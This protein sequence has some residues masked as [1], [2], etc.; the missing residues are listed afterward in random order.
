MYS[1]KKKATQLYLVTRPLYL[2]SQFSKIFEKIIKNR[3]YEF[4]NIFSKIN[5]SHFRFTQN[6]ITN[7]ALNY[8][9]ENITIIWKIFFKYC[10][11]NNFNIFHFL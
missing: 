9:M 2:L 3:I 4:M 8:F 1:F 7:D 6:S 5:E 11:H 10:I